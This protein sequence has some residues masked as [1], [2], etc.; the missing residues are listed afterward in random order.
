[1]TTDQP[2]PAGV[3]TAEEIAKGF[4]RVHLL[5]VALAGAAKI[6]GA[7]KEVCDLAEASMAETITSA[8]TAAESRAMERCAKIAEDHHRIPSPHSD[9][10]LIIAKAIRSSINHPGEEE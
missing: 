2:E 6:D 7:L 9:L 3:G 5:N 10:C 8:I 4:R 1:M